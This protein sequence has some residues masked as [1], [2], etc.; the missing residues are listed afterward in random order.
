MKLILSLL[1]PQLVGAIGALFTVKAI[2]TWYV[3]LNKPSFSP[4]NWLFGPVWLI[5]YL[6]MGV[7]LYLNWIK[8]S[9]QAKYNVRLFFIH[10]FFNAIW[11]PIFFGAKNL[12]LAYVVI[13]IIWAL[14]VVIIINFWKVNKTS[15]LLLIP[16]LLW[17]S[18]ATVL[19]YFV[20]RMN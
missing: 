2:P 13:A 15:S 9:K 10:L 16:Y 5:L 1:L 20:W 3:H 14:I 18:F 17:V 4:P 11:S 12:L 6:I 8:K 19:N 7:A